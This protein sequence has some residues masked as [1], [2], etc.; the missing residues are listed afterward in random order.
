MIFKNN[1]N[2]RYAHNNSGLS[3]VGISVVCEYGLGL[4][5][6]VSLND[7]IDFLYTLCKG[8]RPPAYISV[9]V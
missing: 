3:L 6:C 8:I 9:N 2:H 5:L 4:K 1:K 7:I